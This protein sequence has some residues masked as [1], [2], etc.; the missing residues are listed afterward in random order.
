MMN[1]SRRPI[2]SVHDQDE[3]VPHDPSRS[4][5][6]REPETQAE[7][8]AEEGADGEWTFWNKQLTA[9][10]TGERRWRGE[11]EA[12]E[13]LA[14]GPEED[15]RSQDPQATRS[16]NTIE[17]ATALV[18]GTLQVLKP[19]LYSD[20]PEPVVRR[21]F[22]GDGEMDAVDLMAAEAGQRLARYLIET[23]GFHE[24]MEGVRDNYLIAARGSARAF[25]R[26]TVADATGKVTDQRVPVRATP[27][28]RLL[29]P[30]GSWH[31]LPWLAFGNPMTKAAVEARFGK[32]IADAM[33]FSAQGLIDRSEAKSDSTNDR[34][35]SASLGEPTTDIDN[36]DNPFDTA[37]VW[38]IHNREEGTVVWWS[39][40]Y[41]KG[42]LDEEG[43]IL[44]LEDFFPMPKPLLGTTRGDDMNPRPAIRYY[45]KRA[46]E[47]EKATRKI[48]NILNALSVSGFIPGE[49]QDEV[50]KILQGKNV[51]IP[52]AQWIGLMEKGGA[53]GVIEWLP[54]EA[55]IQAMQALVT[56]REQAKAQMFEA[57][58]VSDVMR[59]QG[60]PSNTAT[61]ERLKGQYAG[62]R[63]QA[64]QS[65]IATYARDLIRIQ[66]EIA[67]TFFSTELIAEICQI[68]LPLTELEREAIIAER[69]R[70][71]DLQQRYALH[72]QQ[73]DAL[74]AQGVAVTMPPPP[75]S[76]DTI[77]VPPTSWEAVHARLRN[78]LKRRISITIETKSTIL[79]DEQADK[80]ARIEFI[81][82][83]STVV[84]ETL[85]MIQSGALPMKTFK[86]LLMFAV[87]GFPKSRT[88]ESQIQGIPDGPAPGADQEETAVTV[89]KIRADV[90]Q[91]LEQMRMQDK[92]LDR[93]H[94]TRLAAADHMAEAGRPTTTR[95]A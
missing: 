10:V 74:K 41:T 58:G 24:A 38:E 72:Q 66:L 73:A 70:L 27:W 90:D 59:A 63:L 4:A 40:S 12:C 19:L 78:D 75:P 91:L 3:I 48:S 50:K 46:K 31:T 45:E 21:R 79:A 87:R 25:Y 53:R 5:L 67:V 49:L 43:D 89:A 92:E 1:D 55:M 29:M 93:Q 51:M 11:A 65:K 26:A 28:R 76:P 47:A 39:E 6:D 30:P 33:N 14:F 8:K 62:L 9:A 64:E 81:R 94:E 69:K 80:E 13:R 84:Q 18:H 85:P 17:D 52:V 34:K 32:E 20:V 95:A 77:T 68:N 86:E 42:L 60:D 57:S 83:V 71:E 2:G 61:Q 54:L 7:A 35:L 16:S 37:M 56:M 82:A 44:E 36:S 23:D 22:F 15:P 88:L